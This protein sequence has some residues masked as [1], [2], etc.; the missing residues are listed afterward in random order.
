MQ[1]GSA[2]ARHEH[3]DHRSHREPGREPT[4]SPKHPEV[5]HGVSYLGSPLR[6]EVRQQLEPPGVI[7]AVV[8][9]AERY[10]G[11][12]GVRVASLSA[13]DACHGM[14]SWS[15]RPCLCVDA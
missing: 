14:S 10:P 3:R 6:V 13:R 4:Q 2:V 8:H 5:H 15:G 11:L 9:P 1:T 7:G 12:T